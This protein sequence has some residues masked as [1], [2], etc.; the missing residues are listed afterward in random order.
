MAMSMVVLDV[1]GQTLVV[2]SVKPDD[3]QL[4]PLAAV[5]QL[6]FIDVENFDR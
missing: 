3:F 2:E 1:L 6:E 4:V 5:A